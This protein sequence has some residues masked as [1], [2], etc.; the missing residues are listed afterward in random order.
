MKIKLLLLLAILLSASTFSRAQYMLMT[1]EAEKQ[2]KFKGESNRAGATA[3][4]EVLGFDYEVKSSRDAGTGQASGR[5]QHVPITIWK[6]SGATSPQF[7]QALTTNETIKNL[8]IEFYKPDDVFKTSPEQLY[9]KIELTNA[10]ITDFRQ[11]M[12]GP[13]TD[14]FKTTGATNLYDGIRIVFEKIT[15][16]NIKANT[17]GTDSWKSAL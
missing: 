11:V 4:M 9:Y 15:V 12:N 14:R 13:E 16:T 2:G 1:A 7:F 10:F 8:T 5:R 17:A 3:K 6:I